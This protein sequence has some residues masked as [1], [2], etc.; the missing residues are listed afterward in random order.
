MAPHRIFASINAVL[1]G[2]EQTAVNLTLTILKI[3]TVV[4]A[5]QV[6]HFT[7]L[8]V[9]GAKGTGDFLD[10]TKHGAVSFF[11]SFSDDTEDKCCSA[12]LPTL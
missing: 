8:G 6:S 5:V 2:T 9:R 11:R 10:R 1:T 12:Q 7:F 3:D 4:R